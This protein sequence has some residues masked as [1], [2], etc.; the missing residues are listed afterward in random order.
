MKKEKYNINVILPTCS[1][2]IFLKI[3]NVN[4]NEFINTKTKQLTVKQAYNSR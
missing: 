1:F 3:L 4:L 2:K